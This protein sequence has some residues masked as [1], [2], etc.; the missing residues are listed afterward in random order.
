MKKLIIHM[1]N[2]DQYQIYV[3]NNDEEYAIEKILDKIRKY[4]SNREVK[5]IRI[6]NEIYI[7]KKLVI[8][9]KYVSRFAIY[10]AKSVAIQV[11]NISS[12][13]LIE[14]D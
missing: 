13:E 5:T 11:N 7:D 1:V 10:C 6:E 9:I 4:A 8:K 12:I 14:V 3:E 2:G